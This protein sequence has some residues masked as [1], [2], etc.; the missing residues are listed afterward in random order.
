MDTDLRGIY[1]PLPT[2][3]GD[4]DQV[5]EAELRRLVRYTAPFLDGIIA[6]G[7]TADF[8]VLSLTER[9]RVVEIV[10]EE[11]GPR[12][13][14]IAGV[15]AIA[16]QE[17]AT[18]AKSVQAQGVDAALVV[19]P[20]YVRP[21]AA[22]LHSHFQAVAEAVPDLAILVYNFPKLMGQ[23][24]PVG[25]VGAL[26]HACSNIIGMKDSSG[27]LPYTL[28]VI[29]ATPSTFNVLVGHGALLLPGVAMGAAGG[30]LAAANLVPHAY[31]AMYEAALSNDWTTARALQSRVYPVAEL[32]ARYGSI[33]VR[34]GFRLLGFGIGPPRA[35]LS[36]SGTLTAMD[37]EVLQRALKDLENV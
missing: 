11:V 34:A 6:N 4:G 12:K 35:P 29:E 27:Q 28:G 2:P 25:V 1:A 20:Y 7:S 33:A 37:T 9:R 18:L 3:F 15:G 16:T 23:E 22:G 24:I 14:V 26:S 30:I 13:R 17:A 31:R 5:D 36:D 32:V 8:P 10:R 21:S 19:T